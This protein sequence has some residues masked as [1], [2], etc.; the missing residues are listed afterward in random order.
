MNFRKNLLN[1]TAATV[2]GAFAI[3][4]QSIGVSMTRGVDEYIEIQHFDDHSETNHVLQVID[5]EDYNFLGRTGNAFYYGI[6]GIGN[7]FQRGM[8]RY[9]AYRAGEEDDDE[10]SAMVEFLES[11]QHA[12]NGPVDGLH[13]IAPA[14]LEGFFLGM[15]R[16]WRLHK[17]EED[18]EI[19][20]DYI[21]EK[22]L[23]DRDR[24]RKKMD[25]KPEVEVRHTDKGG[26]KIVIDTEYLN[27]DDITTDHIMDTIERRED[28]RYRRMPSDT[29][30]A[31]TDL[32]PNSTEPDKVTTHS[33]DMAVRIRRTCS[34]EYL[35]S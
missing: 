2:L 29:S 23:Q 8:D 32:A 21:L 27:D 1:T 7:G 11:V 20:Y 4:C 6:K 34:S 35:H 16:G 31:P 33:S 22:R 26:K 18:Q 28:I 24:R 25:Y 12:A 14:L 19:I 3:G 15:G 13:K 9:K 17:G 10:D 5:K 30:Q